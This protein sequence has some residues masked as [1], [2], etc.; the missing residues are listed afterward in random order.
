MTILIFIL[1][2]VVSVLGGIRIALWLYQGEWNDWDR[3][4]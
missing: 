4:L 2:M 1:M 3:W